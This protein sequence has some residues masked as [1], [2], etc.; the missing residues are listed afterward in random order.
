MA[1]KN[2]KQMAIAAEGTEM[3][4]YNVK[5]YKSNFLPK[6]SATGNYLLTTASLEKSVP[7]FHLPTY[8]PDASGEL[9]PNILTTV[10]GM[11]IFKEYAFFPVACSH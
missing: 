3:A 11:P 8:I 6:I 4:G 9:V 1:L 10:D 2:N 5:A 7:G